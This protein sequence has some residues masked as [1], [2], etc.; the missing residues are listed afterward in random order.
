MDTAQ[1]FANLGIAITRSERP[2]NPLNDESCGF[3]DLKQGR[4][5]AHW[6]S[7]SVLKMKI[8]FKM[9]MRVTAAPPGLG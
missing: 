9:V 6:Y 5:Q 1:H 7:G 4:K 3:A 8:I 2:L